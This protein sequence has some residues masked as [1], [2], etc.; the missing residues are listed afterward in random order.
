MMVNIFSCASRP[1]VYL[2]WRNV[3]LGLL[4]M[5]LTELFVFLIW[6]Y[7]IA[8]GILFSPL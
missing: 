2:L 1:S 8:Q 5:F 4:P 7:C 6:N 3:Y